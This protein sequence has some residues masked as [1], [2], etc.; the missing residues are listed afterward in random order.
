MKSKKTDAHWLTLETDTTV[1]VVPDFGPRHT[2]GGECHCGP[3]HEKHE[4][5][6]VIHE[7]IN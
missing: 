6:L 1:E 3:R 4:K 7:V 2:L 5:M